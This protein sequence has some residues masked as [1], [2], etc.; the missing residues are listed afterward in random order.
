[1]AHAEAM[2]GKVGPLGLLGIRLVPFIPFSLVCFACGVTRVPLRRYAWTMALGTAP[3]TLI[4]VLLGSRLQT[5]SLEDPVIW[6]SLVG[7]LALVALAR[8]LG[9]HLMAS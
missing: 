8:P 2:V 6:G 4:T 9:R 3:L 1:M 7:I 5:P